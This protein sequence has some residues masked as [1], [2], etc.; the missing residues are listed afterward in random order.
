[1]FS[2][3]WE[4]CYLKLINSTSVSNLTT[5]DCFKMFPE[6][7]QSR[8]LTQYGQGMQSHMLLALCPSFLIIFH[9]LLRLNG[10]FFLWAWCDILDK[11]SPEWGARE[12]YIF[13]LSI[14][15]CVDYNITLGSSWLCL[16]SISAE[17]WTG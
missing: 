1:M 14:V 13:P 3:T 10:W 7:F 2:W 15:I 9:Q 17:V 12:W 16:F 8:V 11:S 5:L 6:N 4:N